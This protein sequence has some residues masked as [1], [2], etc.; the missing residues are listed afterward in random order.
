MRDA[1]KMQKRQLFICE[2][3]KDDEHDVSMFFAL[4]G[5]FSSDVMLYRYSVLGAAPRMYVLCVAV[6]QQTRSPLDLFTA[7]ETMCMKMKLLRSVWSL[8]GL[9]I[10]FLISL[11]ACLS[12]SVCL[13]SSVHHV[14][15]HVKKVHA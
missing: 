8:L 14:C 11:C 9:R 12:S 2:S 3:L 15:L 6:L 7:M 5:G 10:P 1:A 4:A 13:L